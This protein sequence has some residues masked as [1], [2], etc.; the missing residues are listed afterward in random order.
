MHIQK[1]AEKKVQKVKIVIKNHDI[2][3]ALMHIQEIAETNSKREN[4]AYMIAEL[5]L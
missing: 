5:T 1:D 4:Y 2:R 3:G